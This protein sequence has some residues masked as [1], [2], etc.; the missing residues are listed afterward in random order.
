MTPTGS[1]HVLLLGSLCAL[2]TAVP[3]HAQTFVHFESPHVHPLEL[4]PDGTRLLAVNT[5]DGR[6]EVFAI[7]NAAPYLTQLGSVPVGLEPVSVRARSATEAWVVN[8]VSDSVS[9]V[10]LTSMTVIATLLTGDE[11]CDVVFAGTPQRAFVSVSQL[12]RLEVFTPTNLLAAPTIVPIVGDDPRALATDGTRVYAAI[13]DGGNDT[14][15]IP[16]TVVSSTVNPYTGD[17]NPPPN[18]GTAFVPP[19]SAGLPTPPKAGIIVRKD[20]A[21]VWRDVNQ[22]DWSAAV[23][24]TL[25]GND[26]AIVNA[27]SLVTTYAKGLM[28]TPMAITTASDGRVVVI[29]AEAKNEIR[30]EPNV[31]GVFIRSEGAVFAAG[32]ALT[33]TSRGDLNPHLTYAAAS[34]PAS[35]RVA[36][37]GDPRGVAVSADGTRGYATGIGSS[38][39]IAFNL[40]NFA[41]LGRCNTGEGPTGVV[42]DAARGKIYTLNRFA[43]SISAIV[44]ATL[45]PVS[46]VPFFDPTPTVVKNGRPFLFDTQISS[47]LGQASCGSCHIDARMDQLSWDLGDPSGTVKIL[48]QVCNL[49]LPLGTCN[50]FH[51]M[52]GPMST[53]TLIGLA[54]TE[55]FHW[56]GDRNDLA[57]FA[58]AAVSLLAADEDF[59]TKEMARLGAYLQT[60]S[61]GPNPNRNLNGTLKTSLLGGNAVTGENLFLNGNLDFVQCA[62]CHIPGTGANASLISGNLLVEPQAMKVPQLRNLFEKV[63]GAESSTIRNRGFG[64][65]HDGATSTLFDFFKLTVFNFAAGVTG[66]Q[67]RRDVTAFML[68]WDTGTHASVGA[69]TTV[70]GSASQGTTR[71]NTLLGLAQTGEAQLVAHASVGGNVRGYLYNGS[72]FTSDRVGETQSTAGFDALS[73]AGVAVT[74]TLLPNGT[75][76][77]VI[78]RDGDGFLDGDERAQCSNPADPASIPGGGCRADLAGSDGIVD[79]ADLAVL[80][81]A[82]GTTNVLADIDCNGIV[83]AADIS[84]LL[85]R[86]GACS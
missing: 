65:T 24:W 3:T 48:D 82:W 50:D 83:D 52:K 4:T 10:N 51:P 44:E 67:Q 20:A 85:N 28:T 38:N 7:S 78:D 58:H 36:S 84:L 71:R 25:H 42:L 32:G 77:R 23:T 81:N 45:V 74:Y 46:E 17:Q 72:T 70:G 66:D 76:M 49:G 68:S 43:G 26:M 15:I 40:S 73:T 47:G 41:R 2:S 56:R 69:Q 37:L 14:T 27:I 16:E 79:A 53:Q 34:I 61:F 55:P 62:T 8:H 31:R 60:I 63:T 12:N 54:G 29:G 35:E 57:E 30:F 19:F 22:K 33:P 80:L 11:P 18:V 64:F 6:L 75:G 39:L 13:F 5:V 21:G 9:V 1:I 86:W 59:S